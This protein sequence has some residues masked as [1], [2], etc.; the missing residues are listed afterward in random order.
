MI[1]NDKLQLAK[2]KTLREHPNMNSALPSDLIPPRSHGGNS[3]SFKAGDFIV[4]H[5]GRGPVDFGVVTEVSDF[6]TI[7]V[8]FPIGELYSFASHCQ[9]YQEWLDGQV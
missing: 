9:H 5:F 8:R 1:Y 2:T 4:E 6:D 3:R 7:S